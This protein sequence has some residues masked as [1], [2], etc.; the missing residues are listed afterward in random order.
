MTKPLITSCQNC[1]HRGWND[2]LDADECSLMETMIWNAEREVCP[3]W[4]Q[5][6]GG[7]HGETTTQ[8]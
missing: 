2:D 3:S 1:Q 6:K 5:L 7:R 4:E 8:A